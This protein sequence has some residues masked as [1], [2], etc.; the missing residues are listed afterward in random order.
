MREKKVLSKSLLLLAI[1][2]IMLFAMSITSFAASTVTNV[3]QTDSSESSVTITYSGD[4]QA[5]G[6]YVY[7]SK[8]NKSWV[9]KDKATDKYPDVYASS[10]NEARISGLDAG[11][12]YYVM[13]VPVYRDANYNY[14]AQTD[15][16]SGTITVVTTPKQVTAVSQTKAT[17]STVTLKWAASA[18]ANRYYVY[19]GYSSPT[20][21]ANVTGTTAT[22]KAAA[23]SEESYYVFPVKVSALNYRAISDY[24]KGVSA[25]AAPGKVSKLASAKYGNL[26]WKSSGTTVT[27]YWDRNANADYI[28]DGYKVEI[29]S[30]D[31][32]KKLKTY[33]ITKKYTSYKKFNIKSIKNKGFKIRVCGYVTVNG[34]KCYGSWSSKVTVIPQGNVKLTQKSKTSMKVSWSKVANATSYTIYACKDENVSKENQKWYKVKTVS[35]KTTSYTVKNLK[36]GKYAGFYVIPTVKI[37]GKKYKADAVWY[38][39]MYMSKYY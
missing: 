29:Y 34:K 39:Y 31:G 33:N 5:Y 37:G 28:P 38:S 13:L 6:Y 36:N 19:R 1:T 10:G 26:N 7:Y 11:T 15:K 30:V 27:V 9:R 4:V 16:R 32:K 35:K 12:A 17:A 3:T 14:T 24:G 22:I 25:K 20:L 18:G 8:D 2:S 21:V 23:G